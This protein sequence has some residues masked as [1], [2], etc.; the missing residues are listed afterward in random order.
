MHLSYLGNS[1]F[2]N[3]K[4]S[5]RILRQYRILR[6]LRKNR[7]I[8]ITKP[9]KGNGVVILGWNLDDNA[10]QEIISDT[11]KFEKLNEDPNFK[12]ESSLQP[13]LPKLKQKNF[14]NDSEYDKF[15]P[16]SSA[17]ACI[18]GTPKMHKFSSSD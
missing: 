4:P 3:C 1:Y 8:I 15:Y 18:Y 6:N 17:P 14:L 5:P 12:H 13:F 9:D 2:Y 16:C 10:I 11:S 7:D